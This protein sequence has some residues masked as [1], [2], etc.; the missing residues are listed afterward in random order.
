MSCLNANSS[1]SQTRA[2]PSPRSRLAERY[3]GH[4]PG[5]LVAGE[6]LLFKVTNHFLYQF[7]EPVRVSFLEESL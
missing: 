2:Y 5:Y 3:L 7:T 1:A 6:F 4:H